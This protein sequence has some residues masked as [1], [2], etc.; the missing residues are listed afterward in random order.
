MTENRQTASVQVRVSLVGPQWVQSVSASGASAAPESVGV[1]YVQIPT[2]VIPRIQI[3]EPVLTV[4]G[5]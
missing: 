5:R 2:A 4:E 3:G 1:K